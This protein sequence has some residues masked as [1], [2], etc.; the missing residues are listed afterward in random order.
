MISSDRSLAMS[1]SRVDVHCGTPFAA[2]GRPP[3]VAG[4]ALVFTLEDDEADSVVL[5]GDFRGHWSAAARLARGEDG[6][7]RVK[8]PLPVPGRYRYK[9]LVDGARWVHDPSHALV[10][11]DG[12][13][14][15]NSI[16]RVAWEIG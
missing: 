16:V 5:Y 3:F 14:G 1:A 12:L 8:L 2:K 11:P 7:F 4:S 9:F 13:G 10:T 15:L 6:V